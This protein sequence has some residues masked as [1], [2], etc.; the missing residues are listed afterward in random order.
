[1]SA[2]KQ[3]FCIRHTQLVFN[4]NLLQI[5]CTILQTGL[6]FNTAKPA[7]C[8]MIFFYL[9]MLW[10]TSNSPGYVCYT[11]SMPNASVN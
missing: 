4:V 2:V 3:L 1:M 10:I 5:P 8:Y 6:L 7:I 9:M 11:E